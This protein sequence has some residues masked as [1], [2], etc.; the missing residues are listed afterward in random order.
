MHND[1]MVAGSKDRPPMLATGRYAQ[2]QSRF[3]IYVD[4]KPNMKELK[5]CIFNG[6]YV[7]TRV[8]V[9]AKPTTETDPPVPEHTIQETYENTLHENRAYIDVEVE[10]IHMILS[11]IGDKIYSTFDAC[12]TT[13]E[14]WTAI[15]RLQQGK[16]VAK[17]RT[18]PSLSASKDDSDP[19]QAKRDK[20]IQKSKALISKYF[21]KIY[22]PTNNNLRTSSNSKNKNVDS[23]LRTGNDKQTGQFKN[24]RT[25]TVAGARETLVQETKAGKRLFLPQGKDDVVQA[26]RERSFY[27]SLMTTYDTEPL[28]QVPTDN[29]YNVFA[30]DRQYSEQPESINDTYVMETVDS[31]VI[32]HHSDMCNNEFKD[33]QNADN[34]DENKR[35]EFVNLIANLK[36]DIDENEK[37]QKQLRKA[38]ATLTHELNESKSALTD[39]N[40]IRD[41]CRSALHQKEVEL[42]K[43]ITYK[44]YQLEKEEIERKYKETLD[45]LAQQKHQFHEALKTQA[46]E[47]FQFKETNA[48]LIHQGSLE[49]IRYDLF[50]KE[51]EQLEK[52]FKISQDKDIDKI[53]ALENQVKFSN[54]VAYK[55]NQSVQT[56]HMLA[57]NPSPYYNGRASF[58]NLI[59]LKKAQSAKPCLYKVPFDKD[60]LANIFAHNSDETLILEEESRSKLDKDLAKPYD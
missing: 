2:W 11:G 28:E 43:Y 57:P 6:P 38:N 30:K 23:T 41:R 39:S 17:P 25:I 45:L 44:N 58:V 13:Q 51:K 8:L 24:Q 46:Y 55:T 34:N 31:N 60:D 3:M 49:N 22:K 18:P 37:I 53:I 16:E 4:T 19:E 50:R 9:L 40:D 21:I 5:K 12:K 42:E 29:E 56:I 27:T 7:M 33:D 47:T 59:Y 1:I 20:D 26:G 48:A 32:P 14:I 35:V 36:L 54:N 52:D 10:A 15:E